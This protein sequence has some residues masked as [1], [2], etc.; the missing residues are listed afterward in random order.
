ML[1]K[2][3]AR[4]PHPD[5]EAADP[6]TPPLLI[7]ASAD[8]YSPPGL[9]R[10]S[11]DPDPAPGL[12]RASADPDIAP[13]SSRASADPAPPSTGRRR[14]DPRQRGSRCPAGEPSRTDS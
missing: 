4:A 11:A 14:S 12:I 5:G 9:I 1:R 13:G 2:R 6:H 8:P 10:A 3:E 7:R